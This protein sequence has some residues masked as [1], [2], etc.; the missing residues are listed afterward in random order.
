MYNDVCAQAA[1]FSLHALL[2]NVCYQLDASCLSCALAP[3]ERQLVR[4]ASFLLHLR[5]KAR[6]FYGKAGIHAPPR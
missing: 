2:T 5:Y 4:P 1:D 3:R 6:F